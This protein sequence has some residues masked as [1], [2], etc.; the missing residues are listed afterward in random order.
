MNHSDFFFIS[1]S[2]FF[3]RP[4]FVIFFPPWEQDEFYDEVG[5]LPSD[6]LDRRETSE[7]RS[8]HQYS[9]TPW[10]QVKIFSSKKNILL[11]FDP[12]KIVARSS[13]HQKC[14]PLGCSYGLTAFFMFFCPPIF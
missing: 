13:K 4:F 1:F 6:L 11:P 2:F 5:A 12:R 10:L 14:P 7:A 8:K 9:P 3:P